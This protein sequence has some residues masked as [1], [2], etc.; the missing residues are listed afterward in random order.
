MRHQQQHL[1]G[2]LAQRGITTTA[3]PLHYMQHNPELALFV[4]A[5]APLG[6]ALDPMTDRRQLPAEIRGKA[7]RAQPHGNGPAFDPDRHRLTGTERNALAIGPIE[8]QRG[9]GATLLITTYHMCGA[10]GTRGR[11]LD[12]ALAQ[13]GIEHFNSER[14]DLPAP[15]AA[16]QT[17]RE[18]YA[19][20]AVTED[21]LQS[22]LQLIRLVDAY[23]QLDAD[24]YWVKLAGFRHSGVRAIVQGGGHLLGALT[25][26]GRPIVCSGAGSLHLALLVADISSSIGLGE[27]E[28][29]NAP[30]ANSRRHEGPRARLIY[31]PVYA[32]SFLADHD[33]V[34][35]AFAAA[36]C[37]CHAH[38]GNKPPRGG[39]IDAHN[40]RVRAIEASEAVTGTIAE[41]REWLRALVNL[42]SHFAADADVDHLAG[43]TVDAFLAGVDAGREPRSQTQAQ[44]G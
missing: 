12:L 36:S 29:Y 4:T 14:L 26:T 15:H 23:S 18:I 9:H 25:Q 13:R 31:H 20:I 17:P 19:G 6:L 7:F 16:V 24:G 35:R 28:S 37:R 5:S 8:L 30:Q 22:P 33:P 21:V 40:V 38:P 44:A 34:R 43:G 39:A 41:R 10:V 27:A 42:A 1:L 2:A 3:A 32:R 11:T